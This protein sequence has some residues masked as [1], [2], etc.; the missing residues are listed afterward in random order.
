MSEEKLPIFGRKQII[1]MYCTVHYC[2]KLIGGGPGGGVQ[3]SLSRIDPKIVQHLIV[4]VFSGIRHMTFIRTRGE[5][6]LRTPSPQQ[7]N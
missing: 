2:T 1:H 4:Y 6:G 7:N 3:K 5:G